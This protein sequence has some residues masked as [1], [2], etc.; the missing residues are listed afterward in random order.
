MVIYKIIKLKT[1]F[2][3][4]IFL[5]INKFYIVYQILKHVYKIIIRGGMFSTISYF[6]LNDRVLLICTGVSLK[7]GFKVLLHL[8]LNGCMISVSGQEL[9]HLIIHH[10]TNFIDVFRS[11]ANQFALIVNEVYAW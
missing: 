9:S 6:D 7:K 3:H 11:C 8:C 10:G 2:Y 5:L 4:I 1:I